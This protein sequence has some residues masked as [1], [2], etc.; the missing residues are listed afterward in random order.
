MAKLIEAVFEKGVFRPTQPVDLEEGQRVKVA[1][2]APVPRNLT[3]E[4][5][6]E[7][8]AFGYGILAD[9]S[10]EDWEKLSASWRRKR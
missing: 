2:P 10:E 5:L 4:E 9:I 7:L 1:L 8:R 3:T 6:N